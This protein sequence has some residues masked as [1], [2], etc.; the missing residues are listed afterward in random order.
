MIYSLLESSALTPPR[1]NVSIEEKSKTSH[2]NA[3]D[4]TFRELRWRKTNVL[5]VHILGVDIEM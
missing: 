4:P 3:V 2:I 5:G 1:P